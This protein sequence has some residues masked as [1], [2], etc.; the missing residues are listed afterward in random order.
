MKTHLQISGQAL[1]VAFAILSS[2]ANAAIVSVGSS[3]PVVNGSDISQFTGA[4]GSTFDVGKWFP[5]TSDPGQTFTPPTNVLFRALTLR[6]G[7]AATNPGFTFKVRVST[8][9]GST[10]TVLRSETATWTTPPSN[11]GDYLT[12]TL[13]TP[14]ALTAGTLYAVDVEFV[15]STK[16]YNNNIPYLYWKNSNAYAGGSYYL[17]DGEATTVT[18]N[19]GRDY[20]FHLDLEHP[21]APIPNSGATVPAGNVN[22]GWS[23]LPPT[24]GTDVWVDVWY[25][26]NPAAL[27]KIIA[28]G[29]NTTATTVS[30]PSAGTYYWRVDSY[31]D[32]IS[33]GSPVQGTLFNFIVSDTDNDGL[34]DSFELAYTS[35]SSATSMVP[36]N[37]DDSDG[38]TNLQEY[39]LGTIPNNPDTDGDTLNDGPEL[40]GVGSRP[41]TDPKKADT[42][43]DGLND[44]AESNT[45]IWVSAAN[46]GTNPILA[47]TDVD[48]LKDGVE[49]KTGTYVSA[50]NTGTNPLA[51]DSDADGAA[52]WY[53]VVIIDKKP[54][55]GSPPNSPN[56]SNL[57]PNIPYPLPDPDISTGVT[58]KP[59]K[60]YIMSGQSNMVGFGQ[61]AGT[62]PGTLQTMTGAENKFPNFV[63]SGGGWT[64][65]QDVKYRGVVSD[66]GNG[67]LKPDVA[68]DKYGP[69]LGFGYV[70]GWYHDEPV[71]LIK[72]SIGNRGL[73]WDYLPPGS[74]RTVSGATTYPAY[75]ESPET[76]ATAG[77]GP[78]PFVWYAGKQYEDCFVAE[79]DMMPSLPWAIGTAFPSSCQLRHNGVNYISKS[80]HT[81]GADSEP[82]IGVNWATFWKF[83]DVAAQ[84]PGDSKGR[85]NV[86][87]ILDNFAADYPAWAAQGFE[88]AGYVW[89][90]GY[91]DTGEPR[92]TRYEPNMVQFI[93]QIR[94]YYENRYPTKTV[95]NA[96]FVIATLAADGGWGNTA[97]GYAK[98]AQ[99]QLNVDGTAGIYPEFA[100]NVKTIEARGF[101]RDSTVSPNGQGYHYNWNAETY[102]LVGD[103]LG[104]AMVDLESNVTPS[105][106]FA[107][108]ATTYPT[109]TNTTASLDFDNGGLETGIEW[110]LGGNPTS[111]ADDSGLAP[112][113]DRTTDPNGKLL[114]IFRRTTAAGVDANTA[115]NVE[116]G[117]NLNGWTTSV[118]QG[119]G[120]NQITI[121]AETN[122]FGAGI[123]KVTVALPPSLADGGKIFARLK[124]GILTP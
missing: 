86:V 25:G 102:L 42:D 34:P 30:A 71:L 28:A 108:W 67:N 76:W 14:L 82:G 38:L 87:D 19:T 124:V 123:D 32:G 113:I 90:Q 105:T 70:M 120:A 41:A 98:V 31:L 60:V 110:V 57:K 5:G 29:L 84:W 49:T 69:E 39:Q 54:A 107:T 83:Y 45:G 53:E 52:D 115:I 91:D 37:D 122:G 21:Q 23:N 12:F 95:P 56:D 74:P 2:P 24:T 66:F 43:G 78:T 6:S 44:G 33:T 121:S 26:T 55:L 46:T 27:T 73:M 103:A 48:G 65:R 64:T 61:I 8:I 36:G 88:I 94:T 96:P 16:P 112:T 40:T 3:A 100:G 117:S 20:T 119:T 68:G 22:L 116:Y 13:D 97:A 93:K 104:R 15:S 7:T 9:S 114:F 63:A 35:P 58:N 47:D 75:G 62:G 99:A 92:A 4:T 118:H 85:G 80:A 109:L 10:L 72:S 51:T 59:V 111:G 1:A 89:W 50:T 18:L 17:F 77:G 101:W 79:S 106:G 11:S 81:G